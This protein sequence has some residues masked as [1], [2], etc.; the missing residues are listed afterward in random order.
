LAGLLSHIFK[1]P[2]FGSN[3]PTNILPNAMR[4]F[5]PSIGQS[6]IGL[7]A[8]LV[9]GS[10]QGWGY[11]IGQGLNFANQLNWMRQLQSFRQRQRPPQW[12]G[13]D[14]GGLY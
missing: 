14:L 10:G 7:G 6:L 13:G 1:M 5:Q 2:S 3:A 12:S 9:D 8:G 4:G 11:G